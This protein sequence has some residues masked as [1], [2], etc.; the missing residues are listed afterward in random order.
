MT[1]PIPQ[2]S[3]Y[4]WDYDHV[5]QAGYLR[6]SNATSTHT[7]PL[8]DGVLNLDCDDKGNVV[9]VELLNTHTPGQRDGAV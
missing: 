5:A 8:I 7:V 4:R 2:G 3:P 9:G 1:N 6:L